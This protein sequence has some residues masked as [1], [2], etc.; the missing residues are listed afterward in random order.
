MSRDIISHKEPITDELKS[1]LNSQNRKLVFTHFEGKLC[2]LY[3][4]QS[5]LKLMQFIR[6]SDSDL[7]GIFVGRIQKDMASTN[8]CFVEY[9]KHKVGYLSYKE[10]K[11]AFLCNRQYDGTLKQGDLILVKVVKE[12]IKTKLPTLTANIT[13]AF[14]EEELSQ[15][16]HKSA[17]SILQNGE[18]GWI[19]ALNNRL[20]QEEYAEVITD[21]PEFLEELKQY[22]DPLEK[23]VRFYKDDTLSLTSLYSLTTKCQ[24]AL[25][26][27]VW[28]KSGAYLVIE[29]TESFNV[30]DV[31]SGKNI[32]KNSSE[33]YIYK[34]NQEAALEIAVQIRLRNLSGIILIDFI[35]MKSKENQKQLLQYM[36][37]LFDEDRIKTLAID[38]T[39]LGIMEVTRY[40]AGK[41]LKQQYEELTKS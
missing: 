27:K 37:E 7:N 21:I 13:D 35:N 2:M 31:N 10:A 41:S 11:A 23:T 22:Y 29:Q 33:D 19:N 34:I 12:G 30:I 32:K 9:Q 38:I 1:A 5:V 24:A 28:L 17:F 14:T 20:S 8:S 3:I 40:K 18:K 36:Q 6:S 39:K 26:Q 4:D 16:S 25:S 15:I